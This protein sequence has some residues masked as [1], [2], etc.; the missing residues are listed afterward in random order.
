M[1]YRSRLPTASSR[2]SGIRPP[3]SAPPRKLSLNEE[4]RQFTGQR[5]YN[6]PGS[7]NSRVSI[8]ASNAR[9]SIRPSGVASA[10]KLMMS[11]RKSKIGL[12]GTTP[13]N[14]R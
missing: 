4:P 13:Q 2:P 6:P 3:G 9:P 7:A 8:F 1:A 14:K 12:F 11:A 10:N 5:G